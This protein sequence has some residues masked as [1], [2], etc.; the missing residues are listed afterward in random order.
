MISN[1]RLTCDGQRIYVPIYG[2]GVLVNYNSRV[3]P[4]V[5]DRGRKYLYAE[6]R[7][8]GK[9]ILGWEECRD[10]TSL[11][12]VEN[13]FVSL[14]LRNDL[15]CS[16]TFGSN[17]SNVQAS[18][19][20]R[21]RIRAVAVLWDSGAELKAEKAIKKLHNQ[22][23]KAAY[24]KING[25]PDDYPR[26]QIMEWAAKVYDAADKGQSYVDFRKE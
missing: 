6:G 21:S 22:S 1:W 26:E 25:Q 2:D 24:W 3:L 16:T 20:G 18:L 13:T 17:V 11:S 23:V 4:G 12:L 15:H 19:I 8:T 7:Y 14:S 5:D 10:W 9:Y